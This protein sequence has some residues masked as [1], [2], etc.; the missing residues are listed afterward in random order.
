MVPTSGTVDTSH[1]KAAA[2]K[3]LLD[4]L[5]GVRGKKV[6][7]LDKSLS[8]PLGLFLKFSALQEHGV[9]KIFWIDDGVI[10]ATQKNIVFLVRCT[11]KN[12]YAIA[13]HVK[14]N[15]KIPGQ[16]FE[17]NVL[18]VPRRTLV[19]EKILEDE[20]V[21]GDVTLGEFPL[22][23]LALEPDL[24]SLELEDSFEELYL[25]KDYT[26]IFYSARA[27]MGIQRRYGLFPRIIGKGD[28]AKRLADALIRM[29]G[30][31]DA[32]DTNLFALTPSSILGELI[33]VDR[34]SD[35]VTPLLTQLTYEGLIDETIGIHNSK[36]ELDAALVGPPQQQQGAATSSSSS[37]AAAPASSS[38]Q[39]RPVLLSSEDKLFENLRDTN[40]AIV[41]NL[42]NKVARRLND[43]YEGRHQA[44]TVSEIR[45]F[46]SKLGGL[47]QEHQS[48]RLHTGLAEEIMK[49]TRSDI[50]NKIL[51]VQ[52]NLA[53]GVD[54]SSQHDAIEELI[55]RNAPVEAILRLLCIESLISQGLKPKDLENFKREILHAYGYNH[56]LT[57]DALEKLQLLQS[58]TTLAASGVVRTNYTN[59]RKT[60]KLIVDEVN[61]H[62]PD[63]ISYVYSGYAPLSIR[64]IQCIIQKPLMTA[65]AKGANAG[66]NTGAAG[67]KG[68][69]DVLKS[70]KGK[71]FDEFQRGE[72]K[73]VRA[74]NILNGQAEKKVT[75]VFFVGGCTFTEIAA[76][77]FIAK[78]EEARRQILIGTTAIINGNK[79]MR[80]AIA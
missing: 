62:N 55:S 65:T 29:R 7:V 80:A 46:V 34:E 30:E 23:F 35:M 36:I 77:R 73:A 20:G 76:L 63:D 21:L 54:P 61:E 1:I 8:G 52:Q 18:F 57:L 16:E 49:H 40:F 37:S 59:L 22:H 70:I 75:V 42:L 11:V 67:W 32:S 10:E 41:G 64:L 69:E 51:E 14:K 19:C 28:C 26:S 58:R 15:A 3:D 79:M 31:E 38:K 13:A 74:R 45:D 39:K 68:F 5:L 44:K 48:L 9:D 56:V 4:L 71:T 17:Y 47:Q 72:D 24:L 53:A 43:D 12:A 33:V 27:L 2:Q 6:L 78:R 60:L 50:F 66:V 25:R